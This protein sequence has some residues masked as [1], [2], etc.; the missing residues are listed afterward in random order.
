L[1]LYMAIVLNFSRKVN[2]DLVF[3]QSP[4]TKFDK[5]P[6]KI[7]N[8]GIFFLFNLSFSAEL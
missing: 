1:R 2:S 6:S 8:G 4:H 5:T 3:Q 7:I